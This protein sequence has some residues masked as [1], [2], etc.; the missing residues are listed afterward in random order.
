MDESRR[1]EWER[2]EKKERR[3]EGLFILFYYLF[4]YLFY[5]FSFRQVE[6]PQFVTDETTRPLWIAVKAVKP[7][8]AGATICKCEN[9]S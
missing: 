1:R 3:E 8:P 2:G 9:D 4:Y 6:F 5:N 7:L